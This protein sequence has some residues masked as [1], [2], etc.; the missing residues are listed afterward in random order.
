MNLTISQLARAVNKSETYI[1]QHIYRKHL[2]VQRDGRKISVAHDEAARWARERQ[3]PFV[4]P[5]NAWVPAATSRKRVARMTVLTQH[6]PGEQHCNLFT[7]IRHRRQDSLGPWASEPKKI[8]AR[9]DLG[10]G[11]RLFSL[12]ASLEHCQTL[13]DHILES[14]TLAIEDI[15]IAYS[16]ESTPRRHWAYRDYRGLTDAS[17]P[18]PFSRHSA[19]IIE[20]W[21]LAQESRKHWLDILDS[22]HGQTPL[23]LSRLGFPLDHLTDRVGNLM[24][25]GAEDTIASELVAQH[26]R[27][28]RLLIEAD[29]LL[30]GAY[31]ATVWASHSGDEVL[32]RE[33]PVA[34]GQTAIEL[35]SD[36]DHIGFAMFRTDDGQCIDLME[37]HLIMEVGGQIKVDSG[38]TLQFHDRRGHL[39]HEVNPA[40]PISRFHVRYDAESVELDKGIRQRWLDRQVR[41]REAATRREGNFERFQPAAFKDAARYVVGLLHQEC[42]QKTP[43]YLADPY[44]V[45]ELT[46]NAGTD[47]NLKNLCL[48]IFAATAGTPLRILCAK[49]KEQQVDPPPWWSAF[50]NQ[51]TAHVSV[52]A[53][54][55]RDG[56]AAGFHD[57]YLITPRREIIITHSINGWHKDGVTFASLPYDVYRA[58]A[59]RLWSMGVGSATADLLVREI[60]R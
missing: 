9:E 34:Q 33:I 36:V 31:S 45:T 40:G 16:L 7:L 13:V 2:S 11:L 58:E 24:I 35:A 19:E 21:S 56:K 52:R 18:S 50:P 28:L 6:R 8:W 26:D 54:R 37:A 15:Q 41:E 47:L 29:E 55:S 12:D 30:P 25:A 4:S 53:F 59:E 38:P 14:A 3:L 32:R 27:T 42:D 49:K 22:H 60:G 48:D 43:I 57:R 46:N 51:L 10:N 44:F 5:A 1:R 23:Q 20:Y 17:I 39:I